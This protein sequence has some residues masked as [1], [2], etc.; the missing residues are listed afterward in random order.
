MLNAL[1]IFVLALIV[2]VVVD[3]NILIPRRKSYSILPGDAVLAAITIVAAI[4][5]FVYDKAVI[6]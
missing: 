6:G 4:A 5:L 2:L 1:H 3:F